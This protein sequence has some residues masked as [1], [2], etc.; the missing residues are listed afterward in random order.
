[1]QGSPQ[2][3][4]YLALQVSTPQLWGRMRREHVWTAAK[5]NTQS[6]WERM[7]FPLVSLAL[8]VDGLLQLEFPLQLIALT[9]CLENT[10]SPLS[11]VK[12]ALQTARI[13]LLEDIL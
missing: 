6:Q 12:P 13:A 8:L 4:A 10:C 5:G 1:M 2:I 11:A 3:P 9:V 7:T